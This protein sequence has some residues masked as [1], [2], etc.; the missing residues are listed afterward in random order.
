MTKRT[1]KPDPKYLIKLFVGTG[2]AGLLAISGTIGLALLIPD[3]EG[4]IIFGLFAVAEMVVWIAA[5]LL[6]GPYYASLSYEVQDDEVSSAW[7][8]S[9]T[10]SS[11]SPIGQ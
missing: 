10:P 2:I 9:P 3:R 7:A 11:T 8:S 6:L 1:F 5:L 4:T